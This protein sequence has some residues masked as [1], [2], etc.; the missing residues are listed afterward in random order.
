[1]TV[2]IGDPKA[3]HLRVVLPPSI[4]SVFCGGGIENCGATRLTTNNINTLSQ[5]FV[6]IEVLNLENYIEE[7]KGIKKIR[8]YQTKGQQIFAKLRILIIFIHLSA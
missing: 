7:P 4:T 8:R 3:T 2:G 6:F 5:I 1:M